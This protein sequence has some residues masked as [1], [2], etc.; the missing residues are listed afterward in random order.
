MVS[1]IRIPSPGRGVLRPAAETVGGVIGSQTLSQTC[2]RPC[3]PQGQGWG[4]ERRGPSSPWRLP[5]SLIEGRTRSAWVPVVAGRPGSI[6]CDDNVS[7]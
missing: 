2:G 4:A 3:C 6:K 5:H 1:P 7:E